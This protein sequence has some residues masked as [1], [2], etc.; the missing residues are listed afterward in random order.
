MKVSVELPELHE[1]AQNDTRVCA[2]LASRLSR[3]MG[4]G[5]LSDSEAGSSRT[6]ED[7]R[8]DERA[9]RFDRDFVED[10]PTKDLEC[11]VDISN[12]QIE[13]HTHEASP[14][15]SDQSSNPGITPGCA[16]ARHDFDVLRMFEEMRDF[17]EVELEI[18]VA[19]EDEITPSLAQ[20]GTKGGAV[21]EIR[22]VMN[23][24]DPRIT[25]L[26]AVD[27]RSALVLGTVIDDDN[28]KRG[29]EGVA[30]LGRA[31]KQRRQIFGLVEGREHQR[32][33]RANFTTDFRAVPALD[34]GF[35][36]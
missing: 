9:Q 29:T 11:T 13:K 35:L 26:P 31:L 7:L 12:R 36:V 21:T 17:A 5:N 33:A 27:D 25:I 2:G 24:D 16:V 30:D 20:A 34:I 28:L 14:D 22:C 3:K 15:P 23:A 18:G 8:I 6:H 1:G 10:F 32:E 19:E 4:Y